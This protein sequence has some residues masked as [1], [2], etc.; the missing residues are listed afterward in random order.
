MLGST[1]RQV[2]ISTITVGATDDT[3][4]MEVE[5]T[6]VDQGDLLMIANPHYQRLIDSYSHLKGVVMEDKDS[7]PFLP[8]HLI[9]SASAFATIKTAEAPHVG[10]PGE[11]VAEKTRFGW[12]IMSPGNESDHSKMFLTQ[13][14]QADY[15]DL[16]R[17]DV[18][19]IDDKPEHDQYAI[20]AEFREQLVRHPEGWYETGLLWKG[21]HPLLPS[22][23]AGSLRQLVQLHSKL[24]RLDLTEKYANVIEQQKSQGIVE[25]VTEPPIE[26]E[27]YIP[28]KPDVRTKAESTKL[29]I[30]YD[31]SA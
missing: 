17:L 25:T 27:F 12:T 26:K 2:S 31:A 28:H 4:K 24:K 29:R 19:G 20:H 8:I 3:Y 22:N 15:E 13:T 21:I 1:S 11:P 6:R 16:C 23:K 30:V 9:L 10:L 14:S 5:V 18:L 7:K